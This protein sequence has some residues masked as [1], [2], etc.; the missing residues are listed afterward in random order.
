MLQLLLAILSLLQNNP[1]A[2]A[3]IARTN[4]GAIQVALPKL[5]R[6]APQAAAQ[7]SRLL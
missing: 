1:A 7:V 4:P 3:S 6:V 5:A 2:L